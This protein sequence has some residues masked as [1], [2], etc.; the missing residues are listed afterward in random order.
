[1]ED[2]RFESCS[3]RVI[4]RW[5]QK[6]LLSFQEWAEC[7][8]SCEAGS[9]CRREVKRAADLSFFSFSVPVSCVCC[10]C[11]Y[12]TYMCTHLCVGACVC[13]GLRLMLGSATIILDH[14]FT[15][16]M[17]SGSQSAQSLLTCLASLASLLWSKFLQGKCIDHGAISSDFVLYFSCLILL[18]LCVYLTTKS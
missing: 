3:I 8:Y 9:A 6:M 17:E 12:F 16:S 1:M 18:L 15:L 10:A 7:K 13:G 2:S 5:F 14:S 11:V 4:L